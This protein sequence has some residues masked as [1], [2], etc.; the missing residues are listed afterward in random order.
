[1][2]TF[3][4]TSG[5]DSLMGSNADD[6]LQGREGNDTLLGGTGL[7]DAIYAGTQSSY[8]VMAMSESSQAQVTDIDLTD[9]N[10]GVDQLQGVERLVFSDGALALAVVPS[11]S[12]P[13]AN[14][15]VGD[16]L[17]LSLTPLVGG[18]LPRGLAVP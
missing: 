7:D 9:G 16:Q 8:S 14:S 2:T 12:Q 11:T 10:E 1:M 13:V 17:N 5:N 6:A 18:G 4:G 15:T 3:N